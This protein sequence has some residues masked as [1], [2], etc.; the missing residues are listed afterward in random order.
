MHYVKAKGL[1]SNNNGMNIYRG[2]EHG[3]I[4]C[5]SRSTCYN[6][7]H[8]FEDIEVKINA[9]EL[10]EH[11]LKHKGKRCMIGTGSMSDPY[12][13]LEKELRLTRKC[14]ELIDKYNY[15]FTVI[16]KSDLILRDL[17]LLKSINKKTKCVVQMTITTFDDGLCRILEPNVCVTSKRIEALKILHDNNIPTIVWMTP[18]LP[19]IN[20]NEANI[21][22]ILKACKEAG[23][24]GIMTFGIGLTLREG[25]RE[26]YYD[27][28]DKYFPGLKYKYIKR[29]GNSY[30]LPVPD[31][32]R[33]NNL[34]INYCKENNMEYRPDKLFEYLNTF[35]DKI[36]GEEISLF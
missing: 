34:L 26:Y 32:Y 4:Y 7:N 21:M 6:M 12:M 3:C 10:L 18:I 2:C 36:H 15:G 5:D 16:T 27:K 35:E 11:S 28:L 20:D 14:L 13:P 30:E 9:P 33:L 8:N 1:L 24:Y 19:F 22:N 17:D 25:D 29:Y 31:E 23:V